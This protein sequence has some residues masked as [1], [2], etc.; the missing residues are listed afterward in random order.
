[1]NDNIDIFKSTAEQVA[2][3]IYQNPQP[4]AENTQLQEIINN[5]NNIIQSIVRI[6]A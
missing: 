3:K 1:M 2:K 6:K 4:Q 5:Y